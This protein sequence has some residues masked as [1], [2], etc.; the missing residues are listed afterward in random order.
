MDNAVAA[1]WFYPT[2][3][4]Y[5]LVLLPHKI[6]N[7]SFWLVAV[8][9]KSTILWAELTS[10]NWLIKTLC[11]E[12][13]RGLEKTVCYKSGGWWLHT[14][15]LKEA[16]FSPQCRATTPESK[17]GSSKVDFPSRAVAFKSGDRLLRRVWISLPPSTLW[18]GKMAHTR[19]SRPE[20]GLGFQVW[21]AFAGE[22]GTWPGHISWRAGLSLVDTSSSQKKMKLWTTWVKLCRNLRCNEILYSKD[23]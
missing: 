11:H 6:V 16:I 12:K 14:V 20:S 1:G 3:C 4:I 8:N 2:Q 22:S 17:K 7:L 9:N 18:R 21:L 15:D 5:S 19:Q 23:H 10:S 13:M